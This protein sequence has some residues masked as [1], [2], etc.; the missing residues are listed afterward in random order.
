MT[1]FQVEMEM[2]SAQHA[3][4][5]ISSLIYLSLNTSVNIKQTI[6]LRVSLLFLKLLRLNVQTSMLVLKQNSYAQCEPSFS[7]VAE[8]G[9]IDFNVGIKTK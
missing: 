8:T 6:M 7:Q 1:K 9:C 5:S 2:N 3:E 4:P